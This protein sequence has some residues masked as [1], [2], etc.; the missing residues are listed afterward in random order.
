MYDILEK[1]E[2]P[3]FVKKL[4]NKDVVEKNKLILEVEVTGRPKPTVTW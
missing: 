2:S 3:K 1:K 4:E